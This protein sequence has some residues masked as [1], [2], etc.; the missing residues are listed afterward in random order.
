MSDLARYLLFL[1]VFPPLHKRLAQTLDYVPLKEGLPDAVQMLAHVRRDRCQTQAW[2]EYVVT[3]GKGE[4]RQHKQGL[5]SAD[6][7][8]RLWT[9]T[10][11]PLKGH[12]LQRQN[13]GLIAQKL[14]AIL[15]D[16]VRYALKILNLIRAKAL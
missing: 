9:G 7:A 15:N 5:L 12:A 2:N 3:K 14:V 1:Y 4:R 16:A 13:L 8:C 10:V 6:P 11:Q